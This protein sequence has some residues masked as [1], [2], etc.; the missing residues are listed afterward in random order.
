M[1]KAFGWHQR[2]RSVIPP[3]RRTEAASVSGRERRIFGRR[4]FKAANIL[5]EQI[6]FIIGAFRKKAR[7]D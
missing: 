7:E 2:A 4:S 5:S 6:N 1:R 3:V